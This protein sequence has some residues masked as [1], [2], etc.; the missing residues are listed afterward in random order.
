MNKA[1]T[2]LVLLAFS[3]T[4][5]AQTR[6]LIGTGVSNGFS[7]LAVS[8]D[9]AVEVPITHHF[10]LDLRDS[11]APFEQHTALGSGWANQAK[12]GNI[13]WLTKSFGLNGAAELSQYSVSISKKGEYAFM[14]ATV[15]TARAM[16]MRLTFDYV[17]E[18]NNG[19]SSNGTES[20][21]LQAGEFNLDMRVGCAGFACYR[22]AFDFMIGR[23]LTQGNPIC[24]GTFGVT[25]GPGGGLCPRIAA[26]SGKFGGVLSMEFPRR[27]KHEEEAF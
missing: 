6:V 18:F 9:T 23:V 19:I 27:R 25:G 10:E 1:Y 20:S 13:V 5:H 12:A 4:L 21:R 16:P 17:R 24:D 3:N 2:T 11:F 14:G 22:L 8:V 15:R 7:N 26:S